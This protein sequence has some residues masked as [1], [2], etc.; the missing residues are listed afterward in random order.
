VKSSRFSHR[1]DN[2]YLKQQQQQQQQQQHHMSLLFVVVYFSHLRSLVV[3]RSVGFTRFV[4]SD[5][6]TKQNRLINVRFVS[7]ISSC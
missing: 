2:N 5:Y 4:N 1:K 6:F 7:F 3:I